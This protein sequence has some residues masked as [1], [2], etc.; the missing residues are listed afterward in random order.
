MSTTTVTGGA[1][2]PLSRTPYDD[3]GNR[4]YQGDLYRAAEPFDELVSRIAVHLNARWPGHSFA[5][6]RHASSGGRKVIAEITAS[7]LDLADAQVRELFFE[8]VRDEIARFGFEHSNPLSD[9]I[10]LSFYTDVTIGDAYWAQR[11]ARNGV[12]NPVAKLVSLAAFKRSVKV[13]DTLTLVAAT[14]AHRQ[15]GI[16]RVV[17]LVGS[18]LIRIAGSYMEFPKAPAFACDGKRI[19]ISMANDRDADAHLVYEWRQQ[20]A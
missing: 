20:A 9:Y 4:G 19:R 17:D 5:V 6:R 12:A 13:G 16:P 10:N 11:G 1:H 8:T 3:R 14:F 15:L 7:P 2:V 18:G